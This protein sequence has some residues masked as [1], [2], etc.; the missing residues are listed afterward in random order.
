MYFFIYRVKN[1]D[2][3]VL[4]IKRLIWFFIFVILVKIK[5]F[6]GEMYLK[7]MFEKNSISVEFNFIIEIVM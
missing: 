3:G 5:I 4:Y 7:V 6:N 2:N 1:D